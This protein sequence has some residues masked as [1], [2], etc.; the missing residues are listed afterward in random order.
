M[1]SSLWVLDSFSHP[2]KVPQPGESRDGNRDAG[3]GTRSG[4]PAGAPRRGAAPS[5]RTTG[6]P[7]PPE[8]PGLQNAPALARRDHPWPPLFLPF[9]SG[10]GSPRVPSAPGSAGDGAVSAPHPFSLLK[11]SPDNP[12]E[13][14]SAIRANL[15][16][17]EG[18]EGSEGWSRRPSCGR[19]HGSSEGSE[20]FSPKFRKLC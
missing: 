6:F 11:P 4:R 10:S 14:K 3:A 19:C 2:W 17:E 20:R 1:H 8:K 9:P 12:L 18:E 13:E 7:L 15:K 16:E 5:P